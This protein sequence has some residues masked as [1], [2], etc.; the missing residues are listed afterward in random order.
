MTDEPAATAD[1]NPPVRVRPEP[2][3][4]RYQLVIA[5]DGTL[6]HGWQKQEPPGLAPLR[7]VQGVV[8]SALQLTLQQPV[9]LVGASRTDTG[10]HARGQSAHFS[11]CTP[12]PIERLA[13]AINSRL[14]DDAD[15]LAARVVPD[16]FDAISDVTSKQYRYRLFNATRRPLDRR[17]AV[18][19]CWTRLDVD[20]M[21][22]AAA[23]LLGR[24]DFAG[25]AAIDHDRKTTVRSILA[26]RV[27]RPVGFEP[28]VHIVVEGDGFLY[29]MVRIIAG[30]LVEVGRG[31]FEPEVV[32]R[33]LATADRRLAGPTLPP[34]GLC[35]EW[36]KYRDPALATGGEGVLVDRSE[37]AH[38][39]APRVVR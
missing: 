26:C 3:M 19:H 29:N 23:R 5:Y 1:A 38:P 9:G 16:S 14:P 22:D 37:P 15:I 12:I 33:I 10:V 7:T 25:L 20:R 6:F 30:T 8:E 11:A 4:R 17:T 34:E 31:R 36:I 13:S 21:N 39:K 27:E 2:V 24:H 18:H 32:D 28:E 35:L